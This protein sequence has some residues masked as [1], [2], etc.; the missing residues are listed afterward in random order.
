[1]KKIILISTITILTLISCSNDEDILFQ[2]T[3]GPPAFP[4]VF[5]GNAYV[6]GQPIKEGM[7]IYAEFGKSKS[8]PVGTLYGRY[9]NVLVA[10]IRKSELTETVN[11]YIEN[12][13]GDR[14]KAIEDFRLSK[15]NEP[16]VVNMSLNF[17]R[18]P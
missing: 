12:F 10:P 15:V 13:D 9:L 2:S 4:H 8:E 16:Y 1:M 6:N 18:Y 14:E 3:D 7:I 5:M 11:F 17:K